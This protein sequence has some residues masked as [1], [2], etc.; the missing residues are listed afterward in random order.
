MN[1]KDGHRCIVPEKYKVYHIQPNNEKVMTDPEQVSGVMH[2]LV[3]FFRVVQ[4]GLVLRGDTF[5]DKFQHPGRCSRSQ[6]TI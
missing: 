1:C 6:G 3:F 4:T 5:L 2:I